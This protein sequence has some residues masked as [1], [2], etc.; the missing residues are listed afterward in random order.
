MD[1]LS[2]ETTQKIDAYWSSALGCRLEDLTT[3]GLALIA[4]TGLGE[5]HGILLFARG[6]SLVVSVPPSR[7]N[8]LRERFKDLTPADL[9]STEKLKSLIQYPVEEIVG[10]AYLGYVDAGTFQAKPQTGARMLTV[11]DNT[12]F[13][14]LRE[15]CPPEDWE[16]GGSYLGEHALAGQFAPDGSLLAMAGYSV[17]NHSIA[18]ISVLTHPAHRGFGLGSGVVNSITTH[19]LQQGLIPQY[20]TLCRNQPS[21]SIATSL[22]FRLYAYST[23]VR[24][25]RPRNTPVE[26]L[27]DD[28]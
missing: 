3:P 14:K 26:V 28:A 23:A 6:N 22:G 9:Q 27:P 21:M 11:D 16:Y 19:A 24:L 17:W 10:P 25:Q 20:R 12:E 15:A 1:K 13:E 2:E 8:V 18:H 4:R 7:M 5:Y